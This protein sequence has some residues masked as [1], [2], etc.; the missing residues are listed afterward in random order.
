MAFSNISILYKSSEFS[1]LS[2]SNS[3]FSSG[4]STSKLP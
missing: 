4:V 1:L 2:S 3:V